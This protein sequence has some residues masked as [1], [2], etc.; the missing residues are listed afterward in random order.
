MNEDMKKHIIKV[1]FI[2]VA[3]TIVLALIIRACSKKDNDKPHPAHNQVSTITPTQPPVSYTTPTLPDVIYVTQDPAADLPETS[4]ILEIPAD[5]DEQITYPQ[6]NP[7]EE[8][9]SYPTVTPEETIPYTGSSD[10][11]VT[12]I[13][14]GQGD[15][16]LIEDNGSAMLIDAGPKES[17]A[18]IEAVLDQY[19]IKTIDTMVLTHNDADHI[20]GAS[21]IIEDYGVGCIYMSD[22]AKETGSYYYL[23]KYISKYNVPVYYPK[24]GSSIPFGTA[25]YE[26]VGPLQGAAY[27]DINSYSIIVRVRHGND[28]FLFTG[29]ATGEETDD[30]LRAGIDVNAQIIKA[31]HHGSANQGCNNKAFWDAVNPEAVVISCARYNDHGHPHKEVMEMTQQRGCKLFRT[32][33]QGTISCISTGNGVQWNMAPSDNYL[34][35]NSL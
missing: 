10:F 6:D 24:A 8:P 33:L 2:L 5:T 14:V 9:L 28:S 25:T 13:D 12:F 18:T 15:C 7:Q 16:A 20:Q 17:V 23:T 26:V 27:E 11:R 19:Q 34:N 22:Y 21:N 31:A 35:G 30:I 29:D 4:D 32:D 3:I 1:V